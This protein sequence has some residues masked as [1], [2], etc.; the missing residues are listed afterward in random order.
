MEFASE[1]KHTSP[2]LRQGLLRV[3]VYSHQKNSFIGQNPLRAKHNDTDTCA[4]VAMKVLL[5]TSVLNVNMSILGYCMFAIPTG[6]CPH[7]TGVGH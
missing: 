6:Q 5:D 1:A 7:V 4:F 3:R 2:D